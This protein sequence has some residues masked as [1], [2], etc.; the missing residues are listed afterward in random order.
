MKTTETP[1]LSF[2]AEPGL[3]VEERLRFKE[4]AADVYRAVTGVGGPVAVDH[5]DPRVRRSLPHRPGRGRP[6]VSCTP[7]LLRDK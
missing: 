5:D 3:T 7:D 2:A 6:V 4:R 1:V